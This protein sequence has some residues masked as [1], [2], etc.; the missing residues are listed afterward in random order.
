MRIGL[1][2][3]LTPAPG[4]SAIATYADFTE[5]VCHAEQLGYHEA[6]VTEHHF[7]EHSLCPAPHVLMAHFLARSE[8]IALGSAAILVGFHDPVSV[9]EEIATLASLAPGR[10]LA[11]FAKGGPFEAQNRAFGFDGTVARDRLREAVPA[12]AAL[13]GGEPVSHT[14]RH[15]HWEDIDLHP[16]ND[17]PAVPFFIASSDPSTIELAARHG[18]GL[19][20]AQ[21]W[22]D[23][24][25]RMNGEFWRSSVP[26]H[27]PDMML[28]RG[29]FIDDDPQR[30]RAQALTHIHDFR[31]RKAQLWGNHKGP[32]ADVP[33]AVIV[34]R[35]LAGTAQEVAEKT[36]ALTALG[37]TR[38]ALNPLSWTMEERHGQIERYAREVMPRIENRH[39][40]PRPVSPDWV[41]PLVM[42][43]K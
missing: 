16:R 10:V 13:L 40:A 23:E 34:E 26:G 28:A 22:P 18:F 9:A 12:I 11:G 7:N 8:R 24:K 33:D 27:T 41:D 42:E 35:M 21:F 6:W 29:L 39:T 25:V 17:G 1:M 37:V 4:Q 20:N 3:H 43:V 14:G 32:L 30:A 36:R 38:L 15:Y 31:A 19:M 2:L 5:L